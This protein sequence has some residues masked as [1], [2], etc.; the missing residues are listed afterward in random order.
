MPFK[1]LCR[2][3]VNLIRV[4]G[5]DSAALVQSL[6]TNDVSLLNSMNNSMYGFFL[7]LSGRVMFDTI[8]YRKESAESPSDSEIWIESHID[9]T[10]S[11]KA[12]LLKYRMRK[13]ERTYISSLFEIQKTLKTV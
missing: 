12:H 11:L 4:K 8:L 9:E 13:K 3:P 7:S 2:V 6:L 10:D 5:K 1:K